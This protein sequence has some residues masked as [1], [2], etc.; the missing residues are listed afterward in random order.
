VDAIVADWRTAP[1]TDRERACAEVAH[2]LTVAHGQA[3]DDVAA[4]RAVALDDRG[5]LDVIQVVAYF[6]FVNRLVDGLGVVLERG[7]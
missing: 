4:L 1:L 5:I 3:H 6:N 2:R 7:R